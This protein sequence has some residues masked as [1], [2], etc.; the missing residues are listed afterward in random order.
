MLEYCFSTPYVV[1]LHTAR[2]IVLARSLCSL[3]CIVPLLLVALV[4][5]ALHYIVA[6]LLVALVFVALV[7][8]DIPLNA[9][10]GSRV[11]A[12]LIGYECP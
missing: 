11:F 3:C 9:L 10:F 4:F 12:T 5:V 7:F 6:L 8:D 2:T 1:T